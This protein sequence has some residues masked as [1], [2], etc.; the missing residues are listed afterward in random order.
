MKS[1]PHPKITI[2]VATLNNQLTIA[3]CLEAIQELE[4]SKESI[5]VI[6][7]DGGS[8]DKTLEIAKKYNVNIL[9]TDLNAPAAYNYAMKNTSSAVIGFVDADAKV[10]KEWLKKLLPHLTNPKVAGVSGGIETWNTENIWSRSIGYDIKYRYSRMNKYASRIATMNLLMKKKVIEE[11]GGF[12]ENLPSQYDTDLGF[13]I[14]SR[15]YKIVFDPS[16][17][18]FHFNRQNPTEYFRQ[19]MQYGKNTLK[20]YFKHSKLIKGDKITDFTLNIQPALLLSSILLFVFG[21]SR[22]LRALWYVSA[23]ILMLLFCYY[24]FSAIKISKEY[25][26]KTAVLLTAI[27]FIRVTAWLTGAT[28]TS[29]NFVTGKSQVKETD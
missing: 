26:D 29:L 6:L 1:A 20:L 28:I 25:N 14:T 21:L 12:D 2:I 8:M 16:T 13:R 22:T 9:P 5:E 11:V 23:G 18:C 4:Y 24:L 17:K 27:Y 7:A 10:E 3:A 19:Q 15:G